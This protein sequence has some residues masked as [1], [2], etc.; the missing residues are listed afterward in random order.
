MYMYV[1]FTLYIK[2]DLTST[3]GVFSKRQILGL[4]ESYKFQEVHSLKKCTYFSHAIQT[5]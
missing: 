4:I 3:H 1:T 5:S 2:K